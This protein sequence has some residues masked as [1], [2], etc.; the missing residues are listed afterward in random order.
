[1]FNENVA[2]ETI[3]LVRPLIQ[4]VLDSG[5]TKRRDLCLVLGY[6]YLSE[7]RRYAFHEMAQAAFGD[8]SAWEHEYRRF[9]WSKARITA[10][11]GMATSLVAASFPHL[12]MPGDTKYW[13]SWI[14][15]DIIAA[16]SGVEPYYDE[17][18][19]KWTVD[20]AVALC[21]HA[22]TQ[23]LAKDSAFL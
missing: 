23:A 12:L 17:M 11:T 14:E 22:H 8:T 2:S 20:A 4:Q 19:S 5:R 6:R 15:G 9:A 7:S 3:G 10:R 16:A 18:F 21:K 13:G 1:M